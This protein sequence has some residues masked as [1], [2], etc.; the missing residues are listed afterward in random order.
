MKAD[1]ITI[2]FLA[3]GAKDSEHFDELAK[4]YGQVE[5]IDRVIGFAKDVDGRFD[6]VNE[7][8]QFYGCFAYDVAEPLGD[9]IVEMAFEEESFPSPAQVLFKAEALMREHMPEEPA[10]SDREAMDA[11]EKLLSGNE[12]PGADGLNQIAEIARATGR[13]IADIDDV[14]A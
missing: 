5:A 14:A 10:L 9:W 6:S 2:A 8:S 4:Q 11:I 12:W 3:L 1:S 13:T 7:R